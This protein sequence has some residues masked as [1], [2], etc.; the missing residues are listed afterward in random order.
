M[1]KEGHLEV[2]GPWEKVIEKWPSAIGTKLAT[3]VK[4]REDGTKK[5]RFIVI[6]EGVA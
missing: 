6:C 3:L 2:I 5:V 4:A 1:V